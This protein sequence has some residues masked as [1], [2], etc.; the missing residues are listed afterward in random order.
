MLKEC[1]IGNMKYKIEYEEKLILNARQCLG[2][3]DYDKHIIFLDKEVQD[4]QSLL[5]T[6]I[7]ELTH[8]ILFE[9]GLNEINTEENVE[10]ISKAL[11]QFYID[12]LQNKKSG[13]VENIQRE[14]C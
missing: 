1:R 7:H 12:N 11:H 3:I 10:I 9:A 5:L 6:L 14:L 13:L 4:E 2:Y 8:G